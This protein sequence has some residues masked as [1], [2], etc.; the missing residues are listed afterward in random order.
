M[1]LDLCSGYHLVQMHT[2]DFDKTAFHAH[3]GLF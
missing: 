2:D 3:E 1:K